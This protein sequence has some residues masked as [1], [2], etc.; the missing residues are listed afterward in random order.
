MCLVDSSAS[1]DI[2]AGEI[3]AVQYKCMDCNSKFRGIGK[4]ISC[5]SCQ[6][7]NVKKI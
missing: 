6:S 2:E 7:V 4:K 5:P 3:S 1:M